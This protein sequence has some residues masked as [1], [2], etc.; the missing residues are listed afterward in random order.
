MMTMSPINARRR[1]GS[2]LVAVS[3]ATSVLAACAIF[4][5]HPDV[6][7]RDGR[8]LIAGALA[9]VSLALVELVIALIPL[10]RGEKWAFW[11]AL[12][13][14][15]S[16]VVPVMLIDAANVIPDHL[17]ITL[18]PFVVGLLLT[19]GGLALAK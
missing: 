10:R 12:V 18:T 6:A 2:V 1:L 13:P 9:I 7:T 4:A 19:F 8:H 15:L 11:A 14:M 16:L 3:Y 17:A 5:T